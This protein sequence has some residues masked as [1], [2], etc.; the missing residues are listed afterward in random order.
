MPSEIVANSANWFLV[1]IAPFLSGAFGI[2]AGWG[3]IREKIKSLEGKQSLIQDRVIKNEGKL[4][5]QVGRP[6]CDSIRTECQLR[7]YEQIKELRLDLK[8]NR[9]LMVQRMDEQ[10]K[11]QE[12]IAE[13]MGMVTK[14]IERLNSK[15]G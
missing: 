13:F 6:R 14:S 2:G 1:W 15:E 7:L 8:E 9:N 11:Q 5:Y 4:E 3:I 10:H 12:K